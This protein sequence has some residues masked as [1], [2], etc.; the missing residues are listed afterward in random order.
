MNKNPA[1]AIFCDIAFRSLTE[2]G[3]EMRICRISDRQVDGEAEKH[4]IVMFFGPEKLFYC[5][6]ESPRTLASA[7]DC[8][9]DRVVC[10][11]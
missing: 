10:S 6:S 7:N 1:Q 9:E 11:R 5:L 8:E 2:P 3:A 4:I